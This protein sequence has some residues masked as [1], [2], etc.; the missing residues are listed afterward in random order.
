MTFGGGVLDQLGNDIDDSWDCIDDEAMRE[1]ASDHV[2]KVRSHVRQH[3]L[4][5]L[6]TPAS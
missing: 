1:A 6:H 2:E 4:A 5:S 3:C